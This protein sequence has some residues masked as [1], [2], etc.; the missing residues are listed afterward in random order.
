MRRE[1]KK[2]GG[3]GTRPSFEANQGKRLGCP[4]EKGTRRKQQKG[5]A[6]NI[7]LLHDC[8]PSSLQVN[9]SWILPSDSGFQRIWA[10]ERP[11]GEVW[12]ITV[13][14]PPGWPGRPH[15]HTRIRWSLAMPPEPMIDTQGWFSQWAVPRCVVYTGAVISIAYPERLRAHPP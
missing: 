1:L 10:H 13:L 11:Q 5:G 12:Q 7:L 15:T 3:Q 2:E 8:R 9:M 4:P 14:S 6:Y